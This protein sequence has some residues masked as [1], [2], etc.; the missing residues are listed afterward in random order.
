MDEREKTVA[1]TRSTDADGAAMVGE[2]LLAPHFSLPSLSLSITAAQLF[3]GTSN[4]GGF[5][6]GKIGKFW[7]FFVL[8][9][10]GGG[11]DVTMEGLSYCFTELVCSYMK[12]MDERE[13][14]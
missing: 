10:G 8:G 6:I 7:G 14:A 11:E 13:R 12:K 4:F 2:V 3:L 9:G 1:K 5:S